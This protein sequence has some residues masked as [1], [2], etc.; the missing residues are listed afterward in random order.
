MS[1][2]EVLLLRAGLCNREMR[3]WFTGCRYDGK[4]LLVPDERIAATIRRCYVP[5][6]QAIG[7]DVVIVS[8]QSVAPQLKFTEAPKRQLYNRRPVEPKQGDML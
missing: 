4:N 1:A 2:L 3:D 5:K 8:G 7:L 6:F